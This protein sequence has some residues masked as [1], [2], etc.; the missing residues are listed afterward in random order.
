[1]ITENGQFSFCDVTLVSKNGRFMLEDRKNKKYVYEVEHD[2]FKLMLIMAA[3]YSAL[4]IKNKVNSF[5]FL[6]DQLE[7]TED[8]FAALL[9]DH[10]DW[11]Q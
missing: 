6:F 3:K 7:L 9:Y 8:I 10:K 1:M 11:I 5:D 4:G 2:T